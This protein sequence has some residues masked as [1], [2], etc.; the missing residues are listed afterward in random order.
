MSAAFYAS[1]HGGACYH[2][3]PVCTG[4]SSYCLSMLTTTAP[5]VSRAEIQRRNLRPCATCRPQPILLLAASDGA[6]ETR[7]ER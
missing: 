6:G 4:L 2:A 3:S 1:P 5:P 7:A